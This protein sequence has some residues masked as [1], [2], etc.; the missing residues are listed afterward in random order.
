MKVLFVAPYIGDTYG[1]T[2]KVVKEVAQAL[3]QQGISLDLITTDANGNTKLDTETY[4]WLNT[5]SYRVCHFPCW[6]KNDLVISHALGNFLVQHGHEYDLVHTHTLFSPTLSF[7]NWLCNLRK[8]P[9]VITPNGML[10]PWA[11]AY[12]AG[13]KR[14]YY[15]FIEKPILC[16]ASLIQ[17][18][19]TS[20]AINIQQ[21]ITNAQVHVVPNGI[22]QCEYIHLPSTEV[23]YNQYPNLLGK[24][25]ILFL[26]RIDPKKGLDL[27]APAF[28]QTHQQFPET[29]LVVAGP[30]GIG[31]MPTALSYF[32]RVGCL[33]AVTFTGM[34]TGDLKRSALAASRL[35]V[36]PSYSEGFSMS[37]LEAMASGLP[38]IITQQC[39]F[40]EAA[41]AKAAYV[42]DTNVDALAETLLQCLH[43]PVDAKETGRRARDLI[44]EQYTW[45]VIA[46]QLVDI[47]KSI[48]E[49]HANNR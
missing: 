25:L 32:Q 30:D 37:I 5:S 39:N 19:V 48:I 6:H 12:K 27:L 29:H 10:E 38:C 43:H 35:Y 45:D 16:S 18:L 4:T 2:S 22:D 14:H 26:G 33:E 3:G 47:Y 31:F 1:G 40:P 36:A 7:V 8:I 15:S 42:I 46:K 24:T 9:Y 34:I 13:K 23:F 41:K 20:E 49:R 44:L 11:L 21:L 28:A 17:A